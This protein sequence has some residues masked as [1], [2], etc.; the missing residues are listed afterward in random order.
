[1][2]KSAFLVTCNAG[3]ERAAS[4]ELTDILN[5]VIHSIQS[6]VSKVNSPID[7]AAEVRDEIRRLVQ[8]KARPVPLKNVRN[9]VL[10]ESLVEHDVVLMC[11]LVRNLSISRRYI[12]NITPLQ[13][14]GP[15]HLIL[16][17][18]SAD[19]SKL[20]ANTGKSYKIMYRQRSSGLICR[21]V[22]FETI[23]RNVSLKVDL[24]CPDYMVVVF[25]IKNMVGY[26]VIS[27]NDA[28]SSAL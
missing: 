13:R 26:S 4:K 12:Q 22:L 14:L 19:L 20:N 5:R 11:S 15:L 16:D 3:R 17:C 18:I 23:T 9:F 21:N 25:V 8:E 27:C 10:L 6:L 7:Y 24:S 28:V 1:M 2:I